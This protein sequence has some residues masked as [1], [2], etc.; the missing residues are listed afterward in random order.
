MEGLGE[1]EWFEPEPETETER[2]PEDEAPQSRILEFRPIVARSANDEEDDEGT[3]EANAESEV[4]A[5]SSWLAAESSSST[6]GRAETN[7]VFSASPTTQN[8]HAS[9][10]ASPEQSEGQVQRRRVKRTP[11]LPWETENPEA[12]AAFSTVSFGQGQMPEGATLATSGEA[13]QLLSASVPLPVR[14]G[15]TV[16]PRTRAVALA[17][18][19]ASLLLACTCAALLLNPALQHNGYPFGL[20]NIFATQTTY[21]ASSTPGKVATPTSTTSSRGAAATPT[22]LPRG[23]G[24]PTPTPNPGSATVAFFVA[25]QQITSPGSMTACPSGCTINGQYYQNSQ[26]F[27]SGQVQS[28]FIPQTELTGSILATNSGSSEWSSSGYAFSG[29]GYTCQ[30]QPVDLPAG[31][32]NTYGCTIFAST[33]PEIAANL[34][35]GTVSGTGVTFTNPNPL[36][37]NGQWQVTASNCTSALSITYQSGQQWGTQQ[38]QQWMQQPGQSG[39]QLALSTPVF[40]HSNQQC[41]QGQQIQFFSAS[42]TTTV[43]DGAFV[44]T[45]AQ[46]AA[47]NRLNSSVPAGYVTKQGTIQECN[48]SGTGLQG[49][50]VLLTC[51]DKATAIYNWTQAMKASL[52]QQVASKSKSQ[53]TTICNGTTGVASN[54]CVLTIDL[55]NGSIMPTDTSVIVI[56]ANIP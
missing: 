29:G 55:G 36:F 32:S 28:T 13:L 42:S 11:P 38:V 39:M 24:G 10:N 4:D 21:A 50:T 34:I 45:D 23:G 49:N 7:N 51:S 47:L 17:L 15:K 30:S 14:T 37:G 1:G 2:S 43:Q 41:P 5:L 48:P 35:N 25:S 53:A 26:S 56:Q 16:T 40:S 8:A 27:N 20:G 12:P 46:N 33:P 3:E 31:T 18:A 22:T 54:S 19:F 6:P 44:A 52:A 9:A